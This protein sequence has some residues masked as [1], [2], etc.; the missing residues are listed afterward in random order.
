MPPRPAHCNIHNRGFLATTPLPGSHLRRVGVMMSWRRQ[1]SAVLTSAYLRGRS[2]A[3]APCRDA[4]FRAHPLAERG[5]QTDQ[6]EQRLQALTTARPHRRGRTR[7]GSATRSRSSG[8]Q[9]DQRDKRISIRWLSSCHSGRG[10][11]GSS[12]SS[13]GGSGS[14]GAP[15][16]RSASMLPHRDAFIV[17]QHMGTEHIAS[18]RR[19]GCTATSSSAAGFPKEPPAQ[20]Q[21]RSQP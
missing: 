9:A 2:G 5:Q 21:A 18:Q 4:A 12:D 1:P 14:T 10:G 8:G 3:R 20:R 16:A 19:M 6:Q 17:L 11:G 13:G 7:A 15:P